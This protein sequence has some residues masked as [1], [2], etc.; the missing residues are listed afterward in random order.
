MLVTFIIPTIGRDF[1]DRALESLITQI[2]SDWHAVIACDGMEHPPPKIVSFPHVVAATVEL[3]Q[4]APP[5]TEPSRC[6]TRFCRVRVASGTPSSTMMTWCPRATFP[7]SA[8]SSASAPTA[9]AVIFRMDDI[10]SASCP[11]GC[12]SGGTRAWYGRDLVRGQAELLARALSRVHGEDRA[13][14]ILSN[15]IH[16]D[17]DMINKLVKCGANIYPSSQTNYFVR[18]EAARA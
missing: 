6:T 11:F 13:T 5:A 14:L 10:H 17:I 9:D 3:G 16:E 4:Q 2:D 15:W 8:A 12:A 1:L 18:P 7:T